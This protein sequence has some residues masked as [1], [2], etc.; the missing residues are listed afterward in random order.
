MRKSII[1]VLLTL[2][3]FMGLSG[4]GHFYLNRFKQ[5]FLFFMG[6]VALTTINFIVNFSSAWYQVGW[7]QFETNSDIVHYSGRI[8]LFSVSLIHIIYILKKERI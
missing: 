1:A 3:A 6:S 2:F 4:M 7:E 8:I 5:G